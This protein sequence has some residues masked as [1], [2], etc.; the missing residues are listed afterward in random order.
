MHLS[1]SKSLC[2]RLIFK[3]LAKTPTDD[4]P[5]FNDARIRVSGLSPWH[6]FHLY[7]SRVLLSWL[8]LQSLNPSSRLRTPSSLVPH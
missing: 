4:I 7:Q 2:G 1:Y 3:L 6:L 8:N 5:L